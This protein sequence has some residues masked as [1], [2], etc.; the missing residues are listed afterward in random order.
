ME[1]HS[2]AYFAWKRAGI[3]N[4]WCWH[5]DAHLD[6]GRDGLGEAALK[7]LEPALEE[8]P[9]LTG[10]PYVPWGGMN[11]GNYLY[12]AIQHGLVGRL[13]WVIPPDLPQGKLLDWARLHLNDW[14]DL[15]VD[16]S[17]GL[18]DAGGYVEG[19]LLGIPFQLGTAA[20]LPM[21][22]EPVLL[23]IDLDYYLTQEGEV[24]SEPPG[25]LPSSLFTTVAFSVLGG[26]TPA[27]ERRLAAP[28]TSQWSGYAGDQQDAAARSVRLRHYETALEQ[29]S[30][31]ETV[32][33]EFLRGTS[34]H[35]L[36]HYAEALKT[37]ERL[38]PRLPAQ[39]Q[40]YLAGLAS[41]LLSTRLND[42]KAALDYAQK[43]LQIVE[44]YRLH[45]A[46]AVALEQL[47]QPRQ[48]GQ[49]LRRGLRMAEG[50]V[51]SLQMR[52]LLARLYRKQGKEGLA[53]I[54]LAQL[55]RDDLGR[56]SGVGLFG[57]IR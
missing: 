19:T 43:G 21:P 33:A 23:D 18:R 45:Y 30:G 11:C 22:D 55:Q 26:Y 46:A 31:L 9:D 48:A 24:W 41:E 3:R 34:Q 4:A 13:T 44:D 53:Q 51:I 50:T 7:Q 47:D 49:M 27:A 29:L 52:R 38:V 57:G 35:H 36:G 2:Q 20:A 25:P 17:A 14:L 10:N 15:T 6:I 37:W 39:G 8:I 5:V 28:W 32:E 54:E 16:E 40:A 12:P 56:P 1:D 42:P